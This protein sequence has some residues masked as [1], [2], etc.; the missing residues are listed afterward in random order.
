MVFYQSCYLE[1]PVDISQ[2]I[3]Y[4]TVVVICN[5]LHKCSEIPRF[6]SGNNRCYFSLVKITN[7]ATAS[8]VSRVA[9]DRTWDQSSGTCTACRHVTADGRGMK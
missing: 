4:Y 8:E 5:I 9:E 1:T 2:M 6:L 3:Y 7:W